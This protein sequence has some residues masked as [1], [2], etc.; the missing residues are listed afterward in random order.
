MT[1]QAKRSIV[2]RSLN[3]HHSVLEEKIKNA[4][5][6][7][8]MFLMVYYNMEDYLCRSKGKNLETYIRPSIPSFKELL[9]SR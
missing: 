1:E 5:Q 2:T 7:T 8:G 9:S 4:F 3:D 6:A